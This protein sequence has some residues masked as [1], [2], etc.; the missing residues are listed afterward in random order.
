MNT[1]ARLG[2][3]EIEAQVEEPPQFVFVY[4][5]TPEAKAAEDA[6]RERGERVLC[7]DYGGRPSPEHEP[8]DDEL[9]GEIERLKARLAQG[10][11]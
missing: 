1:R 8:A 5:G 10:K 7:F 11:R 6:A 3:L 2:R 4:G 9:P